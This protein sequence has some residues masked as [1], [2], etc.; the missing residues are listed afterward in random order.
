MKIGIDLGTSN[1]VIAGIVDGKPRVFR[2]TDGGETLPSAI[3]IDKRGHRLYGRRAHDQALIAPESVVSGFKRLMGTSTPLEIKDAGVT[4]SPEECSADIIRQL[5]A[6]ASTE[7]GIATFESATI[8]IP[9]AFNQMQSEATLR[10]AQSA[11]LANVEFV[12]EP[13]A[14]ALASIANGAARTGQFIVYDFGGGTFD[15][16]LA[17]AKDGVVSILAQRGVNM[18]GGRDFDR[19][20]VN[21]VVRPWLHETFD[22]PEPLTK[23]P[24]YRRLLR[25][26]HLAAER[27]KIDLSSQDETTIL[28]SEDEVRLLDRSEI[29]IHLE[30]PFTRAQLDELIRKPLSQTV[31]VIRLMMEEAEIPLTSVN[32]LVFIGGP[33]RIPLVREVLTSELGIPA[34]L[35]T[36][37]LTAV[38]IGAALYGESRGTTVAPAPSTSNLAPTAEAE[39]TESLDL[40]EAESASPSPAINA[41]T[42]AHPAR[43][44]EDRVVLTLR[45]PEDLPPDL[46]QVRVLAGTWDSDPLP[47][48]E[49]LTVMVPLVTVGENRLVV[50]MLDADGKTVEG[51]D[52]TLVITRLAASVGIIKAAHT[53]AVKAIPSVDAPTNAFVPLV[54]K[55]DSLPAEGQ[56]RFTAARAVGPNDSGAITVEVFQV[57]Y[58][59]R[60]DLNLCVGVFQITDQDLPEGSSSLS[61]GDPVEV[62]WR[63]SESGIL[64]ADIR[65][66]KT[67]QTL[68]G[69]RFYAPQAGQQSFDPVHGAALAKA[70]L[71][72]GEEE[73]GELSAALGPDAGKDLDILKTRL[74]DQRD[75]LGDNPEDPETLRCVVEEA[76]FIRQD[77]ARA[78]R[79]QEAPLLQRRL[80]RTVAVFNRVAR[81]GASP[82]ETGPFDEAAQKVQELL[83]KDDES[84]LVEARAQ[85][86][87]MRHLFFAVAW[88]D[89][90][91]VEAWYKR[92]AEAPYLFPDNEGFQAL[93][94]EGAA[95]LENGNREGLRALVRR[96]LDSRITVGASG[97]AGEVATIVQVAT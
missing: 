37:P 64:Q 87:F 83:D 25:I 66:P 27:A 58:A 54:N 89:P 79:K 40:E 14:A 29:P 70:V 42:F 41:V 57:E 12:P 51:H 45:V 31:N 34:D 76:R 24:A 11:G 7:T 55:G 75:M 48:V 68:K 67:D 84:S 36:D 91:Y 3:Y 65:L 26:A 23:E 90:R 9:A 33:S 59:E 18:L 94:A 5:I 82:A 61:A 50:H 10:A 69:P 93:V 56:A 77:I 81:G 73:W 17:E 88:R 62:L 19:L 52:Q 4:L 46:S 72:H 13:I 97:L 20:I 28:A 78:G 30:V 35:T 74:A 38:A 92:L 60:V 43:V 95:F 47:L 71:D 15:V 32:R 8:A 86:G 6:Q 96:M 85:L 53:L 80:G 21:E 63:M 44:A 39:A 16:A 2:P 1:S 49:G 22:L